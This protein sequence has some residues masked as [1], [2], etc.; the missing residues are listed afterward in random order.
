[1][2]MALMDYPRNT[3]ALIRL[4][5]KLSDRLDEMCFI[6]RQA[7]ASSSSLDG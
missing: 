7:V 3:S 4:L 6:P 2:G 5:V 1:M